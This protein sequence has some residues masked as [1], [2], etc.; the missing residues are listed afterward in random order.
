ML[1]ARRDSLTT[2]DAHCSP[3]CPPKERHREFGSHPLERK[4]SPLAGGNIR[5]ATLRDIVSAA[6]FRSA[7]CL[8]ASS[9]IFA[10]SGREGCARGGLEHVNF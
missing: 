7:E 5:I 6:T 1:S 10:C 2:N 8:T 4:S 3:P 9:C